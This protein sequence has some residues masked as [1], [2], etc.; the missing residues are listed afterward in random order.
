MLNDLI[1]KKR[2]EPIKIA[3]TLKIF[4]KE[5]KMSQSQLAKQL[6]WK[7][8]TV[9][10][11]LRLL[12]LPE[13]IQEHIHEGKLSLSLAK[14]LLSLGDTKNQI[15]LCEKIIENSLTVREAEEYAEE[16]RNGKQLNTVN[17]ED[18]YIQDLKERLQSHL[19]TKVSF[20]TH[21]KGGK[22]SLD[23]HSLDDLEGILDRMH[24]ETISYVD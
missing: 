14:V 7:R 11:Y 13:S 12:T 21:G 16:M 24:F 15:S 9:T 5:K 2:N 20:Q 23:Y 19:G 18:V 4:I 1:V 8:P 17:K 3:K 6:G 10:N 22:I